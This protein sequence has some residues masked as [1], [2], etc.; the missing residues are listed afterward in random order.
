MPLAAAISSL[1]APLRD[2]LRP[3]K[4]ELTRAAIVEAALATA[5]RDGLEGLTIGELATRMRM[6]KSGVFAHFGSREDLQIAVL[7]EYERR[8]VDAILVPALK[9]R[10]GLARLRAIF[11]RWLDQTAIE[12]ARGC[13]W[14]AGAVEYDDRPGPVRDELVSMVNSWQRELLR[15]IQQAIDSGEFRDDVSPTDVVFDLYGAVLALHHD[16]RLLRS[17]DAGGRAH[18]AIERRIESYVNASA[19]PAGKQ[20]ERSVAM[21][22]S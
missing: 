18:R 22:P 4:G 21:R 1:T 17:P 3:R 8:F 15:A 10:R 9:E 7:K 19:D 5:R 12:A 16:V 14:I 6:S 20:N 2:S 11:D 13:I